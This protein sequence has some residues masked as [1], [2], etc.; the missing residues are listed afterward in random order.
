MYQL[1]CF[2]QF[3][4]FLASESRLAARG[5]PRQR[6]PR[7]GH[8]AAPSASAALSRC[9]KG[10]I[11]CR[12]KGSPKPPFCPPPLLETQFV[13]YVFDFRLGI[14]LEKHLGDFKAGYAVG[15]GQFQS[16]IK[17][18]RRPKYSSPKLDLSHNNKPCD[19]CAKAR[20]E[21]REGS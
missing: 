4:Q 7:I 12:I 10:W 13:L 21:P 18:L 5:P 1:Q 14:F 17:P 2:K 16:Q 6:T 11:M 8:N 20:K 19:N 15:P 3:P 9:V